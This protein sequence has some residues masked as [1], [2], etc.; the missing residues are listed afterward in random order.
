MTG[1]KE[2]RD[3]NRLRKTSCEELYVVHDKTVDEIVMITGVKPATLYRWIKEGSWS[4]QK[5]QAMT[6]EKQIDLNLKNA[7]NAGLKAFAADPHN[8]DLQ[9]LVSL[10]KQFKETNKPTQAYKDNIIKF[11][12]K[13]TDYFIENDM[14]ETGEIFKSKL[15][16]IAEY[17]LVKL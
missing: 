10:L 4:D 15:R 1:T 6:Y 16:E 13:T 3:Q 8:K 11:L 7:I 12:D 2:F 17:L 5:T 9:S 14:I